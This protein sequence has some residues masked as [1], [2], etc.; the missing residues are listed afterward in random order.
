M[1]EVPTE[2]NLKNEV[3]RLTAYLM[4][5]GCETCLDEVYPHEND[6]KEEAKFLLE[7]YSKFQDAVEQANRKCAACR[8]MLG[9]A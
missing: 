5:I 9:E 3:E 4:K 7:H 6:A 2:N 8:H 1:S